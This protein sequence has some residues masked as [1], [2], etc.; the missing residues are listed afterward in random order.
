MGIIEIN[1]FS[2]TFGDKV[3]FEDSSFVLNPKEKIGLTGVNG[4]GKST[5]LRMASGVLKPDSGKILMDEQ[6]VYENPSVKADIFYIPDDQYFL[7]NATP[8]DMAGFYQDYYASFDESAGLFC[9]R[10]RPASG[11]RR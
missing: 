1:N 10:A 2:H 4:A 7:P 9:G 5:F 3:L 11:S 8:R 6:P